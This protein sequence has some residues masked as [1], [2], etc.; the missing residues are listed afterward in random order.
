[1]AADTSPEVAMNLWEE[2]IYHLLDVMIY[3]A[4]NGHAVRHQPSAGFPLSAGGGRDIN[5]ETLYLRGIILAR[6]EGITRPPVLNDTPIKVKMGRRYAMAHPMR[7]GG[8]DRSG[9]P[10]LSADKVY[11]AT[12]AFYLGK[13]IWTLEVDTGDPYAGHCRYLLSD[14]DTVERVPA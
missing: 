13:G 11:I 10:E 12:R 3:H 2:P 7:V 4:S 8:D 1:M 14:L 6:T 9:T 5:A